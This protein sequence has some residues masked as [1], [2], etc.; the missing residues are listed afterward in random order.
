MFCSQEWFAGRAAAQQEEGG[1]PAGP[2]RFCDVFSLF[3]ALRGRLPV[4]VLLQLMPTIRP[5]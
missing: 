1:P 5:R 4:E 2:P 3:P